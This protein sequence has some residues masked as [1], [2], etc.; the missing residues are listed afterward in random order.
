M[1]SH[2]ALRS[3]SVAIRGGM[4]LW[5]CFTLAAC[6][7]S[8]KAKP[9]DT[10]ASQSA[11]PGGAAGAGGAATPVIAVIRA[12]DWVGSEWSED[13][14]RVGLQ[15]QNMQE[16]KDY[17]F[18]FSSAQGDPATL[19]ALL[20]AAV[21]AKAAVIV[22]LQDPTLKVAV[23][24][25]KTAPVV[26]HVLSDPFA[27]GAG[28]SDSSHLPNI[29]GVYSPGFGDPEQ[30]GRVKLIRT[31]VPNAKRVGVL[32]SPDE[33]Y[34]VAFKDKLV[35]AGKKAGLTV[36]AV[37]VPTVNDGSTAAVAVVAKKVQAIE[38]F[39]NTA[40]AAFPAI[41]SVTSKANIPV[42]STSPF[43]MSKGAVAAL[44][45]DFAEGGIEAGH[46]IGRIVHGE[47]PA[48]IPFYKETKVKTSGSPANAKAAKVTLPAGIDTAAHK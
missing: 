8:E 40:H 27:A 39:G 25:V 20:D 34:A 4:A 29:T 18:K 35:S 44:Y 1:T 10:T 15:E 36:E 38:I 33:P 24:R 37:P 21:D 22:T 47:S 13:A 9:A 26:F 11:A 12:A 42:F 6:G 31:I 48:K 45:P 17:V 19:P 32:F 16:N 3:A 5:V 14:I 7:T 41:M 46:M 23:Q 43:E 2:A 30:E 28:T